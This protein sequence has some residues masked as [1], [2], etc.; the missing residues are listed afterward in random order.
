MKA[1]PSK[2]ILDRPPVERLFNSPPAEFAKSQPVFYKDPGYSYSKYFLMG[3]DF[4]FLML[5]TCVL[6]M[7]N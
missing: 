3:M 6:C 1:E 4:D 2:F 5:E 7:M